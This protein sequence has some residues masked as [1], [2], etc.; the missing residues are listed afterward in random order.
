MK[1]MNA[2]SLAELIRLTLAASPDYG[3]PQTAAAN[4]SEAG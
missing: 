3:Q 1:K 4:L 2:D